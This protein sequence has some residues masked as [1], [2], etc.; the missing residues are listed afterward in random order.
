MSKTEKSDFFFIVEVKKDGTIQ[1]HATWEDNIEA[2]RV[3][4]TYDIFKVCKEI[5]SDI[6]QQLLAD[7]VIGGVLNVLNSREATVSDKV[8]DAL[9]ARGVEF[10]AGSKTVEFAADAE[11]VNAEVV[12]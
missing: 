1:T 7:R 12:E 4:N 8:S 3:P 6:D 2:E 5:V 10:D 9:K 11:V